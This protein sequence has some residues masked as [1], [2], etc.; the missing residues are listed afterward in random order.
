MTEPQW[1]RDLRLGT[2]IAVMRGG[3]LALALKGDPV[4]QIGRA[5]V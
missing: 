5:H 2:R 3:G 4:A 1:R